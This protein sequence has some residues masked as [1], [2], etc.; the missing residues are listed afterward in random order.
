MVNAHVAR[1]ATATGRAL[2][3]KLEDPRLEDHPATD[4]T[5]L[6]AMQFCAWA[7]GSWAS[8]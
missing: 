8:E 7:T 6:D 4:L 5:L 1:F 3:R 2:S